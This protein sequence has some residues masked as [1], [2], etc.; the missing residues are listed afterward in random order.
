MIRQTVVVAVIEESGSVLLMRRPVGAHLEGYWEFPGGKV[1]AG[2]TL[3]SA[4]FRE[5]REEVGWEI[6]VLE[7]MDEVDYSYADRDVRLHFYRCVRR[8]QKEPAPPL[9]YVW[10]PF[11]KLPR[12]KVPPANQKVVQRLIERET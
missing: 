12:Y 10:V 2:E 5:V 7:K 6:L 3:E 11:Q 9:E 8:T 1:E 4:L